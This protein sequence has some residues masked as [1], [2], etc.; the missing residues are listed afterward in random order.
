MDDEILNFDTRKATDRR[1]EFWL[2]FENGVKMLAEMLDAVPALSEQIPPIEPIVGQTP[3]PIK[4]E[5]VI[6]GDPDTQQNTLLDPNRLS[7]D[8]HDSLGSRGG[9]GRSILK[10]TAN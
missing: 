7:Y 6:R 5:V 8:S 2:E 3:K 10:Q 9:D 1:C 4:K